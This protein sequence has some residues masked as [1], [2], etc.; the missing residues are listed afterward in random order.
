[1]PKTHFWFMEATQNK[2][3]VT[4]RFGDREFLLAVDTC[5]LRKRDRIEVIRDIR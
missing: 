5:F 4:N 2:N 3:H 1:M